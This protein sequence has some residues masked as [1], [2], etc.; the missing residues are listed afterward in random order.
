MTNLN[1]L[2]GKLISRVKLV[3]ETINEDKR[4]TFNSF[5]RLYGPFGIDYSTL[6]AK[7]TLQ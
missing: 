6:R 1:K 2:M 4:K 3:D 5:S 7:G